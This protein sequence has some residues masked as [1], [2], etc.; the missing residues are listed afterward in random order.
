MYDFCLRNYSRE[1]NRKALE[2]LI[3]SGAMDGL[4]DNR[5]QI[6]NIDGVLAAGG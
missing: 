3:K 2:G 1:F 5:R 6:Y 4:E